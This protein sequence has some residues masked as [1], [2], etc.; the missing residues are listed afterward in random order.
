M[1]CGLPCGQQLYKGMSL[2]SVNLSNIEKIM[3]VDGLVDNM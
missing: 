2:S 3:P 1:D